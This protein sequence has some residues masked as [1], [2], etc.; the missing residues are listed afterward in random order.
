MVQYAFDTKLVLGAK[1]LFSH[2]YQDYCT[3]VVME[4]LVMWGRFNC[5]FE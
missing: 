1:L 3:S 5:I 2:I 4:I